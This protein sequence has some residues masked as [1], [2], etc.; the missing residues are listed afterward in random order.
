[1]E[2]I[3]TLEKVLDFDAWGIE[4]TYP[5]MNVHLCEK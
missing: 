5:H 2:W 3:E 1:M 4:M